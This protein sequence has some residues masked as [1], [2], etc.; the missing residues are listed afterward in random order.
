MDILFLV[1]GSLG[2]YLLGSIPSAVWIG[3]TFYGID[4]R[5]HGSGNA[6][7][8]NTLRVLGK[9]A[10]FI[11]LFV[12]CLKGLAAGS[13]ALM[14]NKI[15]AGSPD[16]HNMQMILGGFAVLGHIYPIFAGFKGGKGIATLLGAVIAISWPISLMCALTFV[17]IVWITRY[18]SVGSM[19]ACALS[20]LYVWL[21]YGN[22]QVFI[23]F[24]LVIA[25]MV[26]YT[27]RANIKRLREGNENRFSFSQKK[28]IENEELV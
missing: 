26:V 15:S 1:V 20:P 13:I 7:A 14:Q 6:G 19:L 25:L 4:V 23:Y 16:F 27:H 21:Y 17:I 22:E 28:K 5:E 11:V 2:A 3:T 18:I 10:G 24:C 12:D 8:T 9:K